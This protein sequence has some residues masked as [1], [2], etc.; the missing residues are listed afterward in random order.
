[1]GKEKRD[2]RW[3]TAGSDDDFVERGSWVVLYVALAFLLCRW[4]ALL[5]ADGKG[6]S[7]ECEE[8]WGR[9]M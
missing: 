8:I 5:P 9:L 1:M 4:A 7:A 2:P 3:V 6:V